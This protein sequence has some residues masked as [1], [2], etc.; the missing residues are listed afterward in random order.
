MNL[1]GIEIFSV[2]LQIL[3]FNG[4]PVKNLKSLANMVD[5]CEDEFM[6]FDLEYDQVSLSLPYGYLVTDT[7]LRIAY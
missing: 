7:L 5:N 2:L 1:I 3:A 4:K 6:K